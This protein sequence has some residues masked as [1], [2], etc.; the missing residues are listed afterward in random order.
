MPR[1]IGPFLE[2]A[3]IQ[4]E[5]NH[6]FEKLTD[7]ES[8][9]DGGSGWVPNVDVVE[10]SDELVVDVEVPGVP[11]GDLEVTVG[12]G[13][14]NVEG[15]RPPIEGGQGRDERVYGRFRRSVLLGVPVNTRHADARLREGLLRIRFPKV[16][17]RRGEQVRIEV[18]S[19]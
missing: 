14:L 3:R 5:I 12:D 16:P 18:Q 13:Q 15:V 4:S 17:N 19:S 11:L 6:L 8:D 1:T 7:L 10:H 2:V 9:A